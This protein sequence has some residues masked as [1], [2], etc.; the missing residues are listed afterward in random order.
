MKIGIDIRCLMEKNYS[1]ISEYTYNLL[2]NIFKLDSQNQY[3][4]FYNSRKPVTVPL[5]NQPNVIIKGFHY[6]NKLFNLAMRFL[7]WPAVDQLIGGCDVFLIPNFLFLNISPAC[8]RVL[9][10]H[11]LSF[12]LYPQFFTAKKRL[13][14]TLI[15]AKQ[16]CQLAETIVAIS[17]NT[18]HDIVDIFH[19][20]AEKIV[21]IN[22]GIAADFF[23]PITE[24]QKQK[25]ISTYQ[26][27][28]K[29]IF[30]L[31]NLEPRKNVEC[32]IKAFEQLKDQNI[33][34]V[35]AGS[36]AR[37]YHS[38]N[39]LYQTPPVRSRIKLLGYV[40]AEDRPALY[41][42]AQAFVYP[43]IYEGFGL[44]PL[45]AQSVGTPVV[46]GFN[47]SLIEVV[48]NSGLLVDQNNYHELAETL[49]HVLADVK[50][51]E[52]LSIAGKLNAKKFSW[53]NTSNKILN[54]ITN[55]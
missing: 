32:L 1:G 35:L 14:H 13:W 12:E 19:V 10:V 4:L 11:D 46:V 6:P 15:G 28:E 54:I 20:N 8:R 50:L 3:I 45:E 48:G 41:Q 24:A 34:L 38:I 27:P 47:S 16:Q 36:L 5:F 18:K 53:T 9:I 49:N 17:E 39:K 29:Y 51:R 25:V 2:K 33:F 37:K 23:N 43:S 21:V 31:G 40:A 30:Y 44:P 7:K 55:S 42:L 22:P 52:N 26:L